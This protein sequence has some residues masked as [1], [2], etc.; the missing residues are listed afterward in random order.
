MKRTCLLI[1]A[2]ALIT[3][4]CAKKKEAPSVKLS[5]P[6][7]SEVSKYQTSD[8]CNPGRLFNFESESLRNCT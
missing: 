7:W 6:K 2:L 5:Q 1:F 8:I 3:T 4:F